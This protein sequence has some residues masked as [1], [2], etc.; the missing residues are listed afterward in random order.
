MGRSALSI[1]WRC[2]G[3]LVPI[4]ASDL[5]KSCVNKWTDPWKIHLLPVSLCWKSML[6]A[7]LLALQQA[8]SPHSPC[9]MLF[10]AWGW[11]P[12]VLAVYRD[13]SEEG[14]WEDTKINNGDRRRDG[15]RLQW[16]VEV[17][18]FVILLFKFTVEKVTCGPMTSYCATQ[19]SYNKQNQ[20]SK[21][22]YIGK[23]SPTAVFQR[24]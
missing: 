21:S 17:L 3:Y 16:V 8:H 4:S 11:E 9:W 19:T 2:R 24:Y 15:Q 23:M 7:T 1:S 18:G 10:G 22:H 14:W 5:W 12:W 13:K 20:D 6:K